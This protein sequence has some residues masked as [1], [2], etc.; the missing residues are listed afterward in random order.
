MVMTI[1]MF[2][3]FG[4]ISFLEI[5][6]LLKQKKKHDVYVFSIIML[7]A[8]TLNVLFL[9]KVRIPNPLYLMFILFQPIANWVN[10]LLS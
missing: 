10:G 4:L 6:P 8:F 2:L 3:L 9:F 5:R 7:L 1:V